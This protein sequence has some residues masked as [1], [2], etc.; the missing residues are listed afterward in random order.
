MRLVWKSGVAVALLMLASCA[1]NWAGATG[2]QPQQNPLITRFV[3]LPDPQRPEQGPYEILAQASGQGPL[4]FE[5]RASGGLLSVASESIPVPPS[6]SP[7]V[8]DPNL[9]SSF[10]AYLPPNLW[11]R[12]EVVVTVRD[13]LGGSFQE[14][15]SFEVGANG[16]RLI[17]PQSAYLALP[18]PARFF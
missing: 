18:P 6:A 15:A 5:W 2:P 14:A 11:G 12:Y 17:S 1:P 10:T 9:S 3:V 7:S 4:T 16:T 8:T 13:A